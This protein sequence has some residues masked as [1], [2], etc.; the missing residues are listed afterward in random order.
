MLRSQ[1]T[2][3]RNLPQN[4]R[5]HHQKIKGCN[6]VSMLLIKASFIEECHSLTSISFLERLIIQSVSQAVKCLVKEL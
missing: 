3:Y 4:T 2:P 1:K 5:K 6:Y